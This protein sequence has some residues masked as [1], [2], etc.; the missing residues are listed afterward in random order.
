MQPLEPATANDL[1][2]IAALN[3]A[4]YAEFATQV[5][6]A[7]WAAMRRNLMA[8]AEVAGR[9]EFWVARDGDRLVGSVA[10]GAAGRNNPAIFP[11]DWAAVL[12]LAVDPAARGRGIGRRLTEMCVSRAR[13]DGT[14]VIGLFTS[15]AMSP[16]QHLYETL[17]FVRHAEL[18]RRHG[19]R[20]WLFK[21]DLQSLAIE[22]PR[23]DGHV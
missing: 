6:E 15:E 21:R 23:R 22:G 18:P 14:T 8:V 11:P 5:G 12:L 3:L 16:A 2:A 7:A 20:Y 1:P 13:D 19:L 10:Y 17:G 9:A 4:A